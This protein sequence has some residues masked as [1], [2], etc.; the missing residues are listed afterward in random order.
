VQLFFMLFSIFGI[1]QTY[2]DAM[3][4]YLAA[5]RSWLFAATITSLVCGSFLACI[6]VYLGSE[7]TRKDLIILSA[8]LDGQFKKIDSQFEAIGKDMADVVGW[9]EE[10]KKIKQECIN[11][12]VSEYLNP[13][14]DIKKSP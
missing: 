6:H 8:R 13:F 9:I 10:Q 2:G 14:S 11:K 4:N 3:I 7:R 12:Q 1:Y 5:H